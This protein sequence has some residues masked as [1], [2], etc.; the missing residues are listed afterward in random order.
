MLD[1][2]FD[3]ASCTTDTPIYTRD[4]EVIVYAT[5]DPRTAIAPAPPAVSLPVL[6]RGPVRNV[7]AGGDLAGLF[8]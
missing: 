3:H 5:A 7:S 4:Y 8:G 6:R 1:E 2:T